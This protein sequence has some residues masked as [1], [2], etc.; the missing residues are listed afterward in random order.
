[1]KDLIRK[2]LTDT[3]KDGYKQG[4]SDAFFGF[5]VFITL[6]ALLVA[7]FWFASL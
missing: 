5:A 4:R 6:T 1:M 3:Y 7:G 2:H